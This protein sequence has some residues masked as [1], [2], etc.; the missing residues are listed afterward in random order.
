MVA[1]KTD[2]PSS[3]PEFSPMG[4]GMV[5][6][7]AA[8]ASWVAQGEFNLMG[9]RGAELGSC[10]D[11]DMVLL[12]F[13]S[14]WSIG[15]FPELRLTHL[16]PGYRLRADYLARLYHD[17]NKAWVELLHKHGICPTT[18][19]APWTVPLRKARS[20]LRCRAWAGSAEYVRWQRSCGHFEGRAAIYRMS[21]AGK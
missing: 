16:I 20:Y 2:Y 4:A 5:A 6:R 21:R 1:S 19:A 11:T 14:G 17:H 7:R 3:L 9:R 10:E 8:L 13:A 18:P 15:Y 12:A